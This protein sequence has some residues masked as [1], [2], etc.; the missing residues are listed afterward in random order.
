MHRDA[1]VLILDDDPSITDLLSD[2]LEQDGYKVMAS[3]SAKDMLFLARQFVPDLLLLDLMMPELDGFDVCEFF[4]RDSQLCFTRIVV[5]TARDDRE[6]R[7][8]SYQSKADL[9][10]SKPFEID[11]LRQ[12]VRNQIE[13]KLAYDRIIVDLQ[14]QT[15]MDRNTSSYNRKYLEKRIT[16]ELKRVDRFKRQITLIIV[17]LDNLKNINLHYGFSFGG[18]VL[19]NVAESLRQEIREFDLLGRYDEDSFLILLPDT[20]PNGGKAVVAR[21]KLIIS[22]MV[23]IMKKRL[24]LQST[25]LSMLVERGSKPED[26]FERIEGELIE[27]KARKIGATPH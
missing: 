21:I 25:I 18:E 26:V 12:I 16:E 7:L 19:K 11:E 27:A 8:R 24:S 10:L 14:N 4:K 3:N 6:S 17:H 9:F 15:I 23:F 13:S 22:S 1:K 20:P 2:I 5:L